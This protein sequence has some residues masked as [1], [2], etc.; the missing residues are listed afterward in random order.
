MTNKLSEYCGFSVLF[1][2]FSGKHRI[3]PCR[4]TW[5][6]GTLNKF[7]AEFY[8]LFYLHRNNIYFST[9]V[10]DPI[11]TRKTKEETSMQ[12]KC[13]CDRHV[14]RSKRSSIQVSAT[15]VCRTLRNICASAVE[16]R[17]LAVG[18][19]RASAPKFATV[20]PS[21]HTD[22]TKQIKSYEL[23]LYTWVAWKVCKI[24]VCSFLFIYF[25]FSKWWHTGCLSQAFSST[26]TF[27]F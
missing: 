14:Y 1:T 12:C 18:A 17:T 15:C 8:K 24:N 21:C 6:Q 23:Y 13:I 22:S 9:C 11:R 25:I 3:G 26:F 20:L 10:D 7:W 16:Q 4:L 2:G 5:H 19:G 27:L